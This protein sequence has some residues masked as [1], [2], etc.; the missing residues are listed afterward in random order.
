M[1]NSSYLSKLQL[2]ASLFLGL[3]AF[4]YGIKFFVDG[5]SLVDTILLIVYITIAFLFN[6]QLKGLRVHL[7]KSLNVLEDAVEGNFEARATNIVDHGE[8]GRICHGVNN[9]IDQMET[10]MREMRASVDYASNNEY[11]RKFNTQGINPILAYAGDK[12]NAS[13]MSMQEN[14]HHQLRT[15]LNADLATIN[16]NNEQLI[17]LQKSFMNNTSKLEII[18]TNVKEAAS[19]SIERADDAEKVGNKLEGLNILIDQN[20]TSTALLEDR[21]KEITAIINLISDISDQTNLLALNAAIEAARAGEH[22]RGFA[23]VADEVRKLAEST[24]KATGEIRATVQVLQQ[25][26]IENTANSVEMRHVVGDFTALMRTFQDSMNHLR[27]STEVIDNELSGIQDRIF[28]N[29]IMIDHIVFKTNAYTSINLGKKVSEFGTHTHCRLG[30]WYVDEGK[31]RFGNTPSYA[32]MDKPHAIVHDNVMESMKCL[33]GEDT[34]VVNRDLI[35][36][37]FKAMEIASSELF[38]L[39]EAMIEENHR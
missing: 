15:E 30:K 17:G 2:I 6:A 10:F 4:G 25:E 26:S 37:D 28:I 9:L 14:F 13:I 35:L 5:F 16:K 39:A 21:S 29:L 31:K 3:F 32:K 22:G 27:H 18:S 24:Q 1:T 19:M 20:A 36:N 11:F 38:G 12:I 7:R 8:A 33:E 34:C 23:V